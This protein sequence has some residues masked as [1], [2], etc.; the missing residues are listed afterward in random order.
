VQ[1]AGDHSPAG[2]GAQQREQVI[3]IDVV[4]RRFQVR[5]KHHRRLALL[6]LAVVW[7]ATIAS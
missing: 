5:V 6:P 7:M 4:E 1:P 3:V 2:K